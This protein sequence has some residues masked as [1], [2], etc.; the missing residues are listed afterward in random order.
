MLVRHPVFLQIASVGVEADAHRAD[1]PGG[2]RVLGRPG[3]AHGDVG[4]AAQQVLLPVRQHQ[5]DRHLGV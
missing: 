3:H 1:A 2:Q 4:V 5:L